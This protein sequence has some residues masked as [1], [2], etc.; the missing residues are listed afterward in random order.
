MS[1][2]NKCLLLSS[3]K[4]ISR[5]FTTNLPNDVQAVQEMCRK[6]ADSELKPVAGQN[7]KESKYP[8]KQIERLGEMGFMGI[9]ASAEFGGSNMNSLA[10]SVVVEELSRGD[11]SVGAIV[12]IHNCLY[13]NL[14]DRI[15]NQEQKERWLREFTTGKK[16]GAFALSEMGM[17]ESYFYS[18]LSRS[19]NLSHLRCW[20]RCSKHRDN[21]HQRWRQLHFERN[22]GMGDER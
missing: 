17:F 8:A 21:R 16:I 4:V 11:A 19:Y 9:G 20:K 5:F 13:A 14:V 2:G 7:D 10:L 18:S 3:K 1:L 15:A 12:S 22:K 6:F